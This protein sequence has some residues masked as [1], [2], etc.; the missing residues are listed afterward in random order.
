MSFCFS[1]T[2][3]Y[4]RDLYIPKEVTDPVVKEKMESEYKRI[5]EMVGKQANDMIEIG[6]RRL[7][8]D[9]KKMFGPKYKGPN[10]SGERK[11]NDLLRSSALVRQKC[12]AASKEPTGICLSW[13][14][15]GKK[16][17]GQWKYLL[18]HYCFMSA[19]VHIKQ[20][21]MTD[22]CKAIYD[23]FRELGKPF[24]AYRS[25]NNSPYNCANIRSI[26]CDPDGDGEV[27]QFFPYVDIS[28]GDEL[29]TNEALGHKKLA[30]KKKGKKPVLEQESSS[31][32]SSDSSEEEAGDKGEEESETSGS[33]S[34]SKE[35]DGSSEEEGEEEE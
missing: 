26:I 22:L 12:S 32:E 27:E 6:L 30:R 5:M 18:P 3:W 7:E 4:F 31:S 24:P 8:R 20:P 9:R 25:Y 11:W 17:T 10:W 2:A 28:S 23:D 1:N 35:E 14:L 19:V 16:K 33:R 15:L 13:N 29:E 21:S 34:S